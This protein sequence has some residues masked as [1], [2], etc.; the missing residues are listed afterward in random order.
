MAAAWNI[1][2]NCLTTS[3][4]GL[5]KGFGIPQSRCG[6]GF[7]QNLPQ[8]LL[9]EQ[10]Q[11]YFSNVSVSSRSHVQVMCRAENISNRPRTLAKCNILNHEHGAGEYIQIHINSTSQEHFSMQ[12]Y[13]VM[14]FQGN[15]RFPDYNQCNML[16]K[17]TAYLAVLLV[18]M[19]SHEEPNSLMHT[20]SELQQ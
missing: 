5:H 7:S 2:S 18:Q 6:I 10:P 15:H 13:G 3:S 12:V 17:E 16:A 8:S 4:K 11:I 19:G 14:L 20:C 9:Y 1:T